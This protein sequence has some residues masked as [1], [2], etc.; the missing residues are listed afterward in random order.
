MCSSDLGA[1]HKGRPN[2]GVL[3]KRLAMAVARRSSHLMNLSQ[4]PPR[5][6]GTVLE[7]RS[8]C[9]A[10]GLHKKMCRCVCEDS[11]THFCCADLVRCTCVLCTRGAPDMCSWLHTGC[12][13]CPFG[14]R[15]IGVCKMLDYSLLDGRFASQCLA[16]NNNSRRPHNPVKP[17]PPTVSS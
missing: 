5:R 6:R 12:H 4:T 11:I 9:N 15:F 8:W 13:R 7:F 16:K 3:Q 10:P 17:R 14:A 2:S 1:L